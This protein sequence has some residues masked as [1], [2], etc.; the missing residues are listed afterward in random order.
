MLLKLLHSAGLGLLR[1]TAGG[2]GKGSRRIP[3]G[4]DLGVRSVLERTVEGRTAVRFEN[5]IYFG[6]KSSH[7]N[8]MGV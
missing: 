8:Q 3:H 6:L 7:S 1:C 2:R 5:N 4:E